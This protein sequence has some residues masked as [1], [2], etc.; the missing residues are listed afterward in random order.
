MHLLVGEFEEKRTWVKIDI[1]KDGFLLVMMVLCDDI[2]I[3]NHGGRG[4]ELPN[5]PVV[6]E[7]DN[8]DIE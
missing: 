1:F 2:V 4:L 5:A 8:N 6:M 3:I 7:Y